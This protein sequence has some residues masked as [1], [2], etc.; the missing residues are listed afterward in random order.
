MFCLLFIISCFACG[1]DSTEMPTPTPTSNTTINIL[2]A[3]VVEGSGTSTLQFDVTA[4]SAVESAVMVNYTIKGISAE[5][6]V[7]FTDNA[8]SVEIAVGQRS[9]TISIPVI[10]DALNE[11][12]E[13]IQVT[14]TEA[15]NATINTK[16]AIGV[17][18]DN[19]QP[20][21]NEN[22]YETATNF[23][24]YNLAWSEE[25][26]GDALDTDAFNYDIGDGCPNLCGWGNN[27][28]EWYTDQAENIFVKDGQLTIRATKSGS[29]N[30]NSAKIHTKDKQKFQFGRI[31]IRAKLPEGQGIWPAAWLLGQNIDAVGWPACG[32]ID[33]MEMVGH[34]PKKVHGT[35]HWGPQGGQN[36][37]NGNS[38]SLSEKFS[39]N[40]HVFS[41]VWEANELI[42]Y[43]DEL[44]MH[45]I[46][47]D[48]MQGEQYRFNQAFYMI[49]NV[50]VGG[51]WPGSPDSST[52]FPQEMVVD[53]IRYFQTI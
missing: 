53:Y 14:L 4:T 40:F 29:S 23:Y 44:E 43:V 19:D 31:D 49:L 16:D 22:G 41:L 36:R 32:E 42:W 38:F 30:Y 12:D 51:N 24:G 52:E 15:S 21:Y 5:P 50:A 6:N 35:A 37:F 1:G 46:T 17:I 45:R 33:I 13:K 26:D 48:N 11:V 28:L 27:E 10:D 20:A 39:D 47:P 2:D 8:G 18:R 34:E 3:A 9:A 7:D 25:F